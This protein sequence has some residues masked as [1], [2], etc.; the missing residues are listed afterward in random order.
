ML[1]VSAYRALLL[2]FG[3]V[4]LRTPFELVRA[5]ER[6]RGLRVGH[7]DWYGPFDLAADPHFERVLAG[8]LRERDYW[9]RRSDELAVSSGLD[10]PGASMHLL[11]ER[12]ESELIRPEWVELIA[13]ARDA[14]VI[15]AILTNDLSY[16]HPPEWVERIDVLR[17][18]D[19]LID[20]SSTD[21]LKPDP[22]AF[23]VA[24]ATLGCEAEE[25]LFV[26]DQ[27]FNL[28]GSIAAGIDSL[29]FDVTDPAAA[30]G[31]IRARLHL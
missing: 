27:P 31:Q 22:R 16:F 12:P 17:Q 6:D 10:D 14:G 8:D 25:V 30:I 19:H 23:E 9:A 5:Y 3:G 13:A 20:L 24:L 28:T 2:D 11:F 4:V 7:F 21:Y 29:Q 1:A 26:D 15:V 18:V